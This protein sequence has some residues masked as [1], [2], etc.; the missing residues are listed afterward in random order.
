M[1]WKI[2]FRY[3]IDKDFREDLKFWMRFVEV[4]S[5]YPDG[6]LNTIKRMESTKG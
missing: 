2:L 3:L 6:F 1:T 4:D 5:K